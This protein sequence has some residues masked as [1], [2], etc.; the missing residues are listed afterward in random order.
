MCLS[1]LSHNYQFVLYIYLQNAAVTYSCLNCDFDFKPSALSA[2]NQ[3]FPIGQDEHVGCFAFAWVWNL[4]AVPLEAQEPLWNESGYWWCGWSKLGKRTRMCGIKQSCYRTVLIYLCDWVAFSCIE[5]TGMDSLLHSSIQPGIRFH[6]FLGP[7]QFDICV[8]QAP[9]T[10]L[11]LFLCEWSFEWVGGR[12]LGRNF[13]FQLDFADTFNTE[14]DFHS[15]VLTSKFRN[16]WWLSKHF[17]FPSPLFSCSQLGT[18]KTPFPTVLLKMFNCSPGR[19]PLSTV[20]SSQSRGVLSYCRYSKHKTTT[21]FLSFCESPSAYC[22]F[23]C[24]K[25]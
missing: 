3:Y 8:F 23:L 14:S 12:W 16:L 2:G 7:R 21:F 19:M 11:V 24:M 5:S 10:C 22:C 13:A 4:R 1:L 17:F 18:W 25:S 9:W 6:W 20:Y 15:A